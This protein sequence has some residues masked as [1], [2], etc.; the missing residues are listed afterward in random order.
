MLANLPN[1]GTGRLHTCEEL[2]GIF[3]YNPGVVN[4]ILLE[5]GV[6]HH[7]SPRV[8]QGDLPENERA[9]FLGLAQGD[10]QIG[11]VH[12]GRES[13]VS[14]GT[15]SLRGPRRA[16]LER[17]IGTWG[18]LHTRVK[19]IRIYVGSPG[20]DFMLEPS[21]NSNFMDA[22]SRFAPFLLGM[23]AIGLSEIGNRLSSENG[24]LLERIHRRFPRH[25]G[26]S[27]GCY[28]VER[29]GTSVITV[30]NPGE[31]FGGLIQVESVKKLP[32]LPDLAKLPLVQ[33]G[34]V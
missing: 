28:A 33:S 27:L 26:S 30:Q 6:S 14:V 5:N 17:T 2:A 25:F 34:S 16:L 31:V 9:F 32:F 19:G 7:P 24:D 23:M 1:P 3:G 21:V 15:E 29:R 18:E 8:R 20:F 11:K 13:Y 10:L 22:K 4:R 12:W